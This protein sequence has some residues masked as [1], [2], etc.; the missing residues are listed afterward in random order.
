VAAP[1]RALRAAAFAAG[2]LALVLF[3]WLSFQ[4]YL[5]QADPEGFEARAG[6]LAWVV[7]PTSKSANRAAE[8][9]LAAALRT[10]A[11]S[12]KLPAE[13]LARYREHLAAA[14]RLLVR[15]LR[16]N[17]SQAG[18]LARLAAIRWETEVPVG[19]AAEAKY[20]GMIDTASRMA[21]RMPDVQIRLGELLLK[22]GRQQDGIRYLVRALELDPGSARRVVA[23][24][25]DQVLPAGEIA[26]ALPRIPAVLAA[27]QG[28]YIEDG[29][30][31]DY[32][33]LAESMV[34]VGGPDLLEAWASACLR[35]GEPA[36]LRDRLEKVGRFPDAEMESRRLR[37]RSSARLALGDRDGAVEDAAAARRLVPEDPAVAAH[38]G[39]VALAAGKP[40]EAGRALR[41]ALSLV[42][43]GSGDRRWRAAL[44][45]QIGAAEEAR[46]MPDLAYDAYRNA[47]DLDPSQ[48]GPRRRLAEMKK[49]AGL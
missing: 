14:D 19:E 49:A 28:P 27:L 33:D 25:R 48:E 15:S 45:A 4:V 23:L 9:H 24:L 32:L 42:S 46:G 29:K 18:A 7:G 39:Q 2:A 34:G 20:L 5:A 22:M 16:A 38:L 21:P 10:L 47:L 35:T 17:P 13:R 1:R 31:K 30:G 8:E 3:S 41:D 11:D 44:Y 26:A 36:R 43:R 37:L 12:S 6:P 40:D